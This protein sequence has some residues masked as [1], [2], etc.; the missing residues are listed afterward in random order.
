MTSSYA[1]LEQDLSNPKLRLG[2]ALDYG[3]RLVEMSQLVMGLPF[4][5]PS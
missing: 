2:F 3:Q 4:L 1:D 5:P